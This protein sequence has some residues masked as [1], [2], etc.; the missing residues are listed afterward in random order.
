MP[1]SFFSFLFFSFLFFSFLFLFLFLF[2]FFSFLANLICYFFSDP[3]PNRCLSLINDMCNEALKDKA[4]QE[5]EG[6]REQKAVHIIGSHLFGIAAKDSDVDLL[7]VGLVSEDHF[8]D[9]L[10]SAANIRQAT[11]EIDVFRLV[12]DALHPVFKVTLNCL[13]KSGKVCGDFFFFLHFFFI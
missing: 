9:L 7:C 3:I 11:G 6:K 13:M 5:E 8:W 10:K 1:G 2:L 12:T 4:A